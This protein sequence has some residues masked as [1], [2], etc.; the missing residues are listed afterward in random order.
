MQGRGIYD[1]TEKSQNSK[2]KKLYNSIPF[3]FESF[4]TNKTLSGMKDCCEGTELESHQ[5]AILLP[6]DRLVQSYMTLSWSFSH[7]Q[8]HFALSSAWPHHFFTTLKS[9][10]TSHSRTMVSFATPFSSLVRVHTK[11]LATK[12]DGQPWQSR[13]SVLTGFLSRCVYVVLAEKSLTQASVHAHQT[14]LFLFPRSW[15]L[16]AFRC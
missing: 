6:S 4:M 15:V 8:Q 1:S 10:E 11:H 7:K 5:T 14:Y 3:T 2:L 12:Q 9:H 13:K 16:I